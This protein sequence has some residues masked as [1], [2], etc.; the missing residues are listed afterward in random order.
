ME[1]TFYTEDD[2]IWVEF[3][4]EN[5]HKEES[6]KDG[7]L[8]HYDGEDNLIRAI[9]ANASQGLSLKHLPKKEKKQIAHFMTTHNVSILNDK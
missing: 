6:H 7:V 2:T 4:E 3:N 1:V 9:F 8:L 5:Y